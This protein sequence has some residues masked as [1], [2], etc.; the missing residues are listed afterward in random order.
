MASW[1]AL[2]LY[3][4]FFLLFS[5]D[6]ISL[7][8]YHPPC[9]QIDSCRTHWGE[10]MALWNICWKQRGSTTLFSMK[11]NLSKTNTTPCQEML[12]KQATF[13]MSGWIKATPSAHMKNRKRTNI[14]EKRFWRVIGIKIPGDGKRRGQ[15]VNQLEWGLPVWVA[16]DHRALVHL[17]TWELRPHGTSGRPSSARPLKLRS[18]RTLRPGT[19]WRKGLDHTRDWI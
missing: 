12:R 1:D 4:Y 3:M 14:A 18:C 15:R 8:W 10:G 7:K 2:C 5:E 19:G 16:W 13:S 9:W 6:C 11:N 17:W